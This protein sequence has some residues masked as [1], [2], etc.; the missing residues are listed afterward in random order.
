MTDVKYRSGPSPII[1]LQS[2]MWTAEPQQPL[3]N[4]RRHWLL[5]KRGTVRC[6]KPSHCLFDSACSIDQILAAKFDYSLTL[7]RSLIFNANHSNSVFD[8]WS[9]SNVVPWDTGTTPSATNTITWYRHSPRFGHV[10]I[11]SQSNC[12][13]CQSSVSVI[14]S[15]VSGRSPP[16]RVARNDHG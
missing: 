5:W 8:C 12:R 7:K 13:I 10:I 1:D 14:I 16:G 2:L 9:R 4:S 15:I 6:G 3:I 11:R